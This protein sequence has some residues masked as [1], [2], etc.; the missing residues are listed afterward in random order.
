MASYPGFP[1]HRD[2]LYDPEEDPELEPDEEEQLAHLEGLLASPRWCATSGQR[3]SRRGVIEVDAVRAEVERLRE[4]M[5]LDEDDEREPRQA[6][7][8]AYDMHADAC[9]EDR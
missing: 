1:D 5:G 2:D 8:D 7:Q 6:D 4:S 9:E 3:R